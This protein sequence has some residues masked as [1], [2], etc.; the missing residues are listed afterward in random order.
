M[1]ARDSISRQF[2]EYTHMVMGQRLYDLFIH[3]LD[4]PAPTS[5]RINP[6]KWQGPAPSSS[7]V[8]WS[9]HGYYLAERPNFT[10]DPLLHAGAY[11]VQEAASM[12]IQQVI[13]QH[14]GNSTNDSNNHCTPI[15]ALDMCAAPGG[16]STAAMA[17]LPEGSMMI[18]NEPI[19]QRANILAE[20]ICKWGNANMMVTNNYPEDIAASGLSF[21][22][23][24]CDVPC[25]GEGM[26][27]KDPKSIEE[28]SVGNIDK[29]SKLQREIVNAAWQCLRPGGLMVYSTCTF[30]LR[31][32]EDNICWIA[33]NMDAEI[34]PVHIQ[35]EWHITGSLSDSCP[36]PVYRFIPGISQGE[37]LFMAAI[38]KKDNQDAVNNKRKEKGGKGANRS[39]KTID[40]RWAEQCRQ[41]LCHADSMEFHLAGDTIVAMD[42]NL[43][44]IYQTAAK[45]LRIVH[46]GISLATVRGNALVPHHCLAL[47]TYINREA[48]ATVDTDTQTALD[49]MRRQ[50]ILLPDGTPKGIILLT[51]HGMP[52]GFVKN[53]G[54]RVNNLY[55]QEWRIRNL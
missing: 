44:H 50:P 16:K 14:V 6:E 45:S 34:L 10:L 3:A 37:G 20:N 53:L 47:S 25:S 39:V 4:T 27:R 17:M 41:W 52:I 5:I 54:N 1:G 8:P 21:D 28:W 12:F 40:R 32:N 23:I 7:L 22:L 19:K 11:Y 46:A 13:S 36:W 15:I 33:N 9:E 31:E 51:H 48:F 35:D 18:C 55:P 26:F 42:K 38:R 43:K 49:Y 2:A 30:N 29:C 24:I